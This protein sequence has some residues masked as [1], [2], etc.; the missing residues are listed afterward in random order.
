MPQPRPNPDTSGL[1]T[2]VP[3]RSLP[4][5]HSFQGI[6]QLLHYTKANIQ[7]LHEHLLRRKQPRT[8]KDSYVEEMDV[9]ARLTE[10]CEE[11]KKIENPD[12]LE[13][14][15]AY[16]KEALQEAKCRS[17]CESLVKLKSN[18]PAP[19]TKE[20]HIVVNG[21]SIKLPDTNATYA[22]S[23]FSDSGVESEPCSFA[24]H[25]NLDIVLEIAQGQGPYN[26]ER[27]FPQLLMKPDDNVKFSLGSHCT[28]STSA[29]SEI[30]SS[31]T[32]INSLLSDDELSPHENSKKSI[33]PECQLSNSKTVLNLGTIDLPKCEETKKSSIILQQ[34]SVVFSEH[35]D[36][37]TSVMHSLNSSTKDPLLLVFSDKDTSSGVKAVAA[38]NLTWIL[39]VKSPDKSHNSS[40]TARLN[41]KLICLGAHCVVS[42]SVSTN[43]E[44]S[45]DRTVGKKSSDALHLKQI[46]SEVPKVESE[47]QLDTSDPFPASTD[48]VKQ[49]LVENYFGSQSITDISDT[50][51]VNYSNS[52][53]PQ[54]ENHEK[55]I[56]NV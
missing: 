3:D 11:V 23:R 14:Q 38:P 18:L 47:T 52:G 30:Q 42:G 39:H 12:E 46:C 53:S 17:L 54:K 15:T 25:S 31:L 33:V 27:L 29:L 43:S 9:E 41:S 20:Y 4:R 6:A 13:E 37:E 8:Q 24:T 51:D 56:S 22:S 48:M 5:Y 50:C 16:E 44:V 10:L 1:G 45:K 40:R 19:S 34:Q 55:G 49:G 32:S 26:N 21:D 36:N 2:E 35:L 7:V 28:E